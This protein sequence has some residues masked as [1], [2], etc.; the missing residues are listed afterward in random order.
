MDEKRDDHDKGS[1]GAKKD[2]EEPKKDAEETKKDVE[3]PKKDAQ[4]PEEALPTRGTPLTK[5][6]VKGLLGI[7]FFRRP[8]VPAGSQYSPNRARLPSMPRGPPQPPGRR[9]S[10]CPVPHRATRTAI[11]PQARSRHPPQPTAPQGLS[12]RSAPPRYCRG[13]R[14]VITPWTPRATSAAAVPAAKTVG[15]TVDLAD[16]ATGREPPTLNRGLPWVQPLPSPVRP[17]V[18]DVAVQVEANTM[19]RVA[20]SATPPTSEG[21]QWRRKGAYSIDSFGGFPKIPRQPPFR[22]GTGR[23]LDTHRASLSEAAGHEFGRRAHGSRGSGQEGSRGPMGTGSQGDRIPARDAN[24]YNLATKEHSAVR[25]PSLPYVFVVSALVLIVLCLCVLIFSSGA[26]ENETETLHG[27]TVEVSEKV[28][29]SR[30]H[31]RGI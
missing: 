19:P 5:K 3:E 6:R 26:A 1:D 25:L 23:S 22:G 27:L 14:E 11:L 10:A 15:T 31:R 8:L 12:R 17:E 4:E 7:V 28:A 2:A 24:R 29:A 9:R 30:K 20:D 13:C 16:F 21:S 18:A